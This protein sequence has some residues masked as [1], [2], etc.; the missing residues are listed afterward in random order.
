MIYV[1]KAIITNKNS[2]QRG[3][4]PFCSLF[5]QMRSKIY[6]SNTLFIDMNIPFGKSLE[7]NKLKVKYYEKSFKAV[8]FPDIQ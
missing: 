8:R 7:S 5:Q 3:Y 1:T 4:K 2:Q 6:I